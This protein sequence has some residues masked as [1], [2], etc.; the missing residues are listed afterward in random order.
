MKVRLAAVAFFSF[1]IA[2]CVQPPALEADSLIPDDAIPGGFGG[3]TGFGTEYN[4]RGVSQTDEEP[5][6]QGEIDYSVGVSDAI[7]F[8]VSVWGSNV[9]F[10]DGDEASL[11]IDYFG[12][13]TGGLPG[14]PGLTWDIG[15][16]GY[17]YPGVDSSLNYD[18]AEAYGGLGYDF[19][20]ASAAAYV[21]YTPD[22]FGDTGDAVYY[23]GDIG[24]P[25]PKNLSLGFHVGRFEFDEGIEVVGLPDYTDWKIGLTV[26]VL[27]FDLE[28]A[29]IDTDIDEDECGDICDSRFYFFASRSF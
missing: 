6:V 1:L 29:Y 3:Y 8:Y 22:F 14:A 26:A 11:E 27:G 15:G 25:L 5:S 28:F 24:I 4:W 13:F 19:G 21:H 2:I 7:D 18:F 16:I 9:D 12:G 20:V 17:T 10:G 23:F